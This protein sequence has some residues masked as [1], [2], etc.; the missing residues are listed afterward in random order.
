MENAVKKELEKNLRA[1]NQ[2]FEFI[3][4]GELPTQE[5][6]KMEFD[7]IKLLV[8]YCE[9]IALNGESAIEK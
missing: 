7:S 6:V 9:K 8:N 1:I 2:N 3:I 4:N 5:L